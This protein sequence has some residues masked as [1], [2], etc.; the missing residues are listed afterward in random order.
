MRGGESGSG[1]EWEGEKGGREGGGWERERRGG[2]EGEK[3]LCE[4]DL[5]IGLM[6]G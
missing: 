1:Q 5:K 4:L 3:A 6:G 2:D